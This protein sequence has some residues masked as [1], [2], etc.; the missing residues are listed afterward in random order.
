MVKG[1][2]E[3]NFSVSCFFPC[4]NDAGTIASMVELA[5]LTLKKLTR[6]FEVIVIDDGSIDA[7]REI[8][9]ELA[10]KNKYLK[11]VFH[12]KNQGYGGA[13]ISGFKKSSKDI[14]F[15]TDGDF[16][17]DIRELSNLLEKLNNKVDIVQGYKVKRFDPW[18]R[19]VIGDIYNFGVKLLFAIKIRDVD[20]D[21]RLIRKSVFDKVELKHKSG[22]I[23]V[24]MVKKMQDAGFKF[25]QVPVSHYNRVYGRSQFFNFSRVYRVGVE[26]IDLWQ[27][28]V[29]LK[30]LKR[31][32]SKDDK[33]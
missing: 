19:V 30:W 9:K 27:E 7:S 32:S 6:D 8:L 2:L 25:A 33:Y 14:I 24:E 29:F 21:F 15:Y 4:F 11:L 16:Q 13:L 22:V 20:C 26:I 1:K 17:Y 18:F 23:T 10:T 31:I 12:Q 3:K 5:T 28:L